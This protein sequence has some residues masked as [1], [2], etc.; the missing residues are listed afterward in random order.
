MIGSA[1]F[2][3]NR[4]GVPII[5]ATP[6]VGTADVQLSLPDNAFR[7]LGM[8]GLVVLQLNAPIAS[9]TT[10]T[11]PVLAEVNGQT[12]PLSNASGE[13]LTAADL[14]SV[15]ALVVLFDKAANILQVLSQTI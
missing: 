15:T 8:K 13:A 14:G 12:R 11:L 4:G 7:F 10:G 6:T 2:I 9:G 3:G 1:L 5:S